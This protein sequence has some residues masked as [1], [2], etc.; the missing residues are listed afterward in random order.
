MGFERSSI[1]KN[2]YGVLCFE[3]EAMR[4]AHTWIDGEPHKKQLMPEL[5]EGAATQEGVI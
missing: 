3:G 5:I 4:G 1:K 2:V